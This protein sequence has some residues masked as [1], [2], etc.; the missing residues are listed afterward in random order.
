MEPGVLSS[1]E[2]QTQKN[3][4]VSC[5]TLRNS[6]LERC[7]THRPQ[8]ETTMNF[9]FKA[10]GDKAKG[11]LKTAGEKATKAAIDIR[12]RTDRA[13]EAIAAKCTE[14]TGRETTATEVKRAVA[15]VAGA[16]IVGT[17]ALTVASARG[18][19]NATSLASSDGGW[20]SDFESQTSRVFAENGYS[21]NYYT[22]HVDSTGTVYSGPN[23]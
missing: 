20:G 7:I 8:L 15:I 6:S 18:G 9:D 2:M 13:A 16:V 19:H 10:F 1:Y 12:E 21:L 22:P 5:H 3:L 17:G 14:V 23:G 11:L 4:G